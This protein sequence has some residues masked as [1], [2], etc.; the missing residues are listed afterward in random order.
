MRFTRDFSSVNGAIANKELLHPRILNTSHSIFVYHPFLNILF[1]SKHH[2][3]RR[4]SKTAFLEVEDTVVYVRTPI[5]FFPSAKCYT[6]ESLNSSAMRRVCHV[7]LQMSIHICDRLG[8]LDDI[9]YR[10]LSNPTP[11]VDMSMCKGEVSYCPWPQ[12]VSGLCSANSSTPCNC[13]WI[14]DIFKSSS[15]S[16]VTSAGVSYNREGKSGISTVT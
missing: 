8:P 6:N 3:S 12:A 2:G 10:I 7:L 11:K 5:S 4:Y 1:T 15:S 16:S 9:K 13:S 14:C